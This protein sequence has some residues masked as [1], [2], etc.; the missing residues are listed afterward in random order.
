MH[1]SLQTSHAS[2]DTRPCQP[3]GP[4]SIVAGDTAHLGEMAAYG[5]LQRLAGATCSLSSENAALC[6]ARNYSERP[7][8]R[9][10]SLTAWRAR[11]HCS[12]EDPL[13]L[14]AAEGTYIME[15]SLKGSAHTRRHG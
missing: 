4:N 5:L 9:R 2:H 13:Q 3:S 6:P 14:T 15:H 10:H 8:K 12:W 7:L 1:P 11:N